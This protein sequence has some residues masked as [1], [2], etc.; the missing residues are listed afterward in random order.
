MLTM[1]D[2]V[3]ANYPNGAKNHAVQN[4]YRGY[5]MAATGAPDRVRICMDYKRTLD[6]EPKTEHRRNGK[7][8]VLDRNYS[9]GG[10][11]T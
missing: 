9:S 5:A 3:V 2:I 7:S 4:C 1:P 8:M 10:A 11:L 6:L